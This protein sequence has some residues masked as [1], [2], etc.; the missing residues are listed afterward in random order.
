MEK[1]HLVIG[2]KSHVCE[3]CGQ[4]IGESDYYLSDVQ[5]CEV[6]IHCKCLERAKM[7]IE[8]DWDKDY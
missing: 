6:W 2:K 5:N 7:L 4:E 3:L 8:I 1:E